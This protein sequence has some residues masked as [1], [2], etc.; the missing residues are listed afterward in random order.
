MNAPDRYAIETDARRTYLG[1]TD[2]S[3]IVGASPWG[4]A[5][6]VWLEKT[7]R[8]PSVEPNLAMQFGTFAEEFVA[9]QYTKATGLAL[10]RHNQPL[11]HPD[12]PF[13]AGH[14]DRLVV[15]PGQ[16]VASKRGRIATA[17]IW[18]GKTA[19]AE[20]AYDDAKWGP[21]WTD[22]VPMDYFWQQV[23]YLGLSGCAES[24]LTVMFGSRE[25]RH[26]RIKANPALFA[27]A[28]K[29]AVEFWHDCVL[30]DRVPDCAGPADADKLWQADNGSLVVAEESD[31]ALLAE[32]AERSA[33]IK[34]EE[35]AKEA[36]VAKL[37]QRLGPASALVDEK[38]GTLATWKSA[39]P[40]ASFDLDAFLGTY[41]P[42]AMDVERACLLAD[43]RR[44]FTS[45]G[46]PSRRFTLKKEFHE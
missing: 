4:T 6:D 37:K 19:S 45:L 38:G 14:V 28:V 3:K 33:R 29:R 36:A 40:R 16:K 41:F 21:E 9:Q 32:I 13:L 20:Q 30:A 22:A 1:G 5:V 27:G 42:G 23:W 24:H 39:K 8:S 17:T 35:E 7:G 26:Y 25:I 12:Y 2:I 34:A 10:R 31:R 11:I 44:S 43:V 15:P 18:E 46:N